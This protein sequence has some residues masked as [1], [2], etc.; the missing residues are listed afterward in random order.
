MKAAAFS[1]SVSQQSGVENP[2]TVG[3]ASVVFQKASEKATNGHLSMGVQGAEASVADFGGNAAASSL[4]TTFKRLRAKAADPL[5]LRARA[6]WALLDAQYKADSCVPYF[7]R[8][9][10]R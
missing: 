10:P 7:I 3:I 9:G 1:L 6:L 4:E 2:M 5:R 8:F